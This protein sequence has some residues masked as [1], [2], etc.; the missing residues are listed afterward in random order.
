MET[1]VKSVVSSIKKDLRQS[2]SSSKD[3]VTVMMAMMND[4]TYKVDELGKDGQVVSTYCPAE[5]AQDL[6]ATI[7]KSATKVSAAE[8]DELAKNH[9]FG[10]KEATAMVTMSKEF[11]NTYLDCGRK[12]KFG[13]R[14][15]KS[16][17]LSQKDKEASNCTF[18]KRTGYDE[19]GKP[20]YQLAST[21]IAAYKEVKAVS[22][23][24]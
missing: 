21:E 16:L 13:N 11:V 12:I 3:E 9:T 19:S 4:K 18:P 6:A 14:E 17:V 15:G 24:K 1:T 10:R 2:S 7:I 20:I 5:V 23:P 22:R 8:A